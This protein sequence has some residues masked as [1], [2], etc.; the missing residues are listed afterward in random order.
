MSEY[1][2]L[3]YLNPLE[4]FSRRPKVGVIRLEGVIG[5]SWPGRRGLW[6]GRM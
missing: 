2:L 1:P 3:S 5:L 4:W 6:R